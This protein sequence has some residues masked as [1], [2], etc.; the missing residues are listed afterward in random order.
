MPGLADQ[1]HRV[2][3]VGDIVQLLE[4]GGCRRREDHRLDPDLGVL[5]PAW[6]RSA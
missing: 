6:T 4:E 5:S 2:D 1:Q 3:L